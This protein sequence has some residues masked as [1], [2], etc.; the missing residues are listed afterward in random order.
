MNTGYFKYGIPVPEILTLR[1]FVFV[2]EAKKN[3][4][5]VLLDHKK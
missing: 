5:H 3:Y 4:L 2:A 1:E